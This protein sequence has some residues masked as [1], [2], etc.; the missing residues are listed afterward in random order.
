MQKMEKLIVMKQKIDIDK[1]NRFKTYNFFKTFDNPYASVVSLVNV[2]NIVKISKKYDIS[3]YG[4]MTY[5]AIKT[6]NEIEEFKY[7]LE[8]EEIYRYDSIDVT[9]AVLKNNNELNFTRIIKYSEFDEFIDKF[10]EAKQEA[11]SDEI[12]PYIKSYNKVYVTCTPWMRIT[13]LNNPAKYNTIDSVPRICW[14]KYFL[15]NNEYYIDLAIQVNH[16]FQDGYHIGM[17]F[18]KLNENITYFLQEKEKKQLV[19]KI[20]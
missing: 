20:T 17:F 16:A 12:V 9:C 6:I 5:M 4:L 13:G 1:W 10:I 7:V 8:D 18:S 2:D 19:R 11:E 14:G 3:F 15:Q